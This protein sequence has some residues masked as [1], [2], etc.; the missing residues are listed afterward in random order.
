V[1]APARDK[2]GRVLVV[3]DEPLIA[4]ILRRIL[5]VAHDV[6]V[7]QSARTAIGR[8]EAGERFDVILCDLM[9]P[10]MT[11][12]EFYNVVA[13]RA[14]A[15]VERIVFITGGAFSSHARD[16]LDRVANERIDKPF[17]AA[18]VRGV[19]RRFVE[20]TRHGTSPAQM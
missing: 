19:V 5:A 4:D 9:M 14:P 15:C 17:D 3:D 8:L 10:D 6:V 18:R 12:M 11:G 13:E 16:F 1:H 2:R 7:V 20:P